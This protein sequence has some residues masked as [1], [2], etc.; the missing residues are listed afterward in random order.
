MKTAMKVGLS[1]LAAL[2]LTG[3]VFAQGIPD[4]SNSAI[5]SNVSNLNTG[6]PGGTTNLNS[7]GLGN[8][9]NLNSGGLTSNVNGS[10]LNANTNTSLG[11]PVT[12][13]LGNENGVMGNSNISTNA[14]EELNEHPGNKGG[15]GNHFG[16]RNSDRGEREGQERKEMQEPR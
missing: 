15:Q 5:G 16:W 10:G 14:N 12:G 1:S 4:G 9:A 6:V 2:A 3:A 11:A 8:V 7:G 13:G